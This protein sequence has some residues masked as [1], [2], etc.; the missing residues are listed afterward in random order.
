MDPA[1]AF[2]HPK[3]REII[4][5][6]PQHA[7]LS[8]YTEFAE[9]SS[10]VRRRLRF[11]K[12]KRRKERLIDPE[13]G[14]EESLE[15]IHPTAAQIQWEKVTEPPEQIQWEKVTEQVTEPPEQIQWEKVTEPQT[16]PEFI[17]PVSWKKTARKKITRKRPAKFSMLRGTTSKKR[18][19]IPRIRARARRAGIKRGTKRKQRY[20]PRRPIGR[21]ASYSVPRGSLHYHTQTK[22][23][24]P[25][26]RK[27][28][29]LRGGYKIKKPSIPWD[30]GGSQLRRVI[31]GRGVNRGSRWV[32]GSKRDVFYG[33]ADYTVGGLSLNDLVENDRGKVV[34]KKQRALAYANPSLMAHAALLK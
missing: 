16:R 34:S 15:E 22:K 2:M 10:A 9:G 4:K 24:A 31:M 28:L 11:K 20:T 3:L 17:V 13:Y 19:Y 32:I 26:R 21:I 25:K 14:L 7:V 23:K 33:A 27:V 30:R 29:R 6:I 1:A 18:V 8:P 5:D 12:K